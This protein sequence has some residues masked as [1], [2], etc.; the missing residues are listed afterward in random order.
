MLFVSGLQIKL[1]EIVLKYIQQQSIA[2]RVIFK[3]TSCPGQCKG[4][5]LALWHSVIFWP[6]GLCAEAQHTLSSM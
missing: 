4:C 3:A 2:W 6:R 1:A 5:V